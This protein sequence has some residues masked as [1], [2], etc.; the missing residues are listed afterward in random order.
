M[1][2]EDENKR[3][4]NCK[5]SSLHIKKG[6]PSWME[7]LSSNFED[8]TMALCSSNNN[9]DGHD[10]FKFLIFIRFNET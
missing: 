4:Y 1:F 3:A 9:R 7:V 6:F 10:K 2:F 8:N 5:N